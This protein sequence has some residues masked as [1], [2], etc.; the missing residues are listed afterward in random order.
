MTTDIFITTHKS[1]MGPNTYEN[2]KDL[3]Y[4]A[5][6]RRNQQSSEFDAFKPRDDSYIILKINLNSNLN[7][8][9][10]YLFTNS[11]LS[12]TVKLENYF[13]MITTF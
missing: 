2:P 1:H 3:V 11:T 6:P 10:I 9:M 8:N 4:S 5:L 12:K 7:K 13:R